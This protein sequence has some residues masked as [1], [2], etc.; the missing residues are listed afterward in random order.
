MKN[1]LITEHK[2]LSLF[3][4]KIKAILEFDENLLEKALWSY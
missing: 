2:K 1:I 3:P 4:K